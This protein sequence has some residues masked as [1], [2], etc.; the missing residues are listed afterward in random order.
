M[1]SGLH[2]LPCPWR[3][4]ETPAAATAACRLFSGRRSP[5]VSSVLP[6]S[7][8]YRSYSISSCYSFNQVQHFSAACI[9][10]LLGLAVNAHVPDPYV[11]ADAKI[12]NIRT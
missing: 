3:A 7:N 10:S 8:V 2:I 9:S 1:L 11:D 5:R 12:K 4:H 6:E